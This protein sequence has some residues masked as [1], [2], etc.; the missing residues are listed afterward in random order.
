MLKEVEK[1]IT[2]ED[3][4]T[5][6]N[7]KVFISAANCIK[8]GANLEISSIGGEFTAEEMG[9]ITG[10]C[11]QGDMLPYSR[12]RLRDYISALVKLREHKDEKPVSEMTDD[13]LLAIIE[14]KRRKM[15]T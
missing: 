10:I 11:K 4:P 9:R 5:A 8:S 7:R 6:F 3:F 14:E 13:E 12:D 15:S 1:S 2:A